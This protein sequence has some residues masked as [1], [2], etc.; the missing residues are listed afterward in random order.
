VEGGTTGAFG[1][2]GLQFNIVLSIFLYFRAVQSIAMFFGYDIK[3]GSAELV[4]ASE[5]FTN[6]LSPAQNDE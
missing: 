5:V 1:F 3:N 4:I 2:W 6:A